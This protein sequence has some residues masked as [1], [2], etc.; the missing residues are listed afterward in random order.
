MNF[1][2]LNIII[3]SA[4]LVIIGVLFLMENEVFLRDNRVERSL[5]IGLQRPIWAACLSWISYACIFNYGGK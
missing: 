1:Q 5:Y 3:W 4:V 2:F